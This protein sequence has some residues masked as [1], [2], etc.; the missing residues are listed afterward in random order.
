MTCVAIALGSN[1]GDREQY[2]QDALAA[3]AP[4][5]S[6]TPCRAGSKPSLSAWPGAAS[7]AQRSCD[8]G[9]LAGGADLLARM[10]EIERQLGRARPHPGAARTSISI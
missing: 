2:L 6:I 1:V 9:D 4:E 8:G 10:L 5:V 7:G 3:L